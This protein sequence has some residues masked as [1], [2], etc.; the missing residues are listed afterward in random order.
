MIWF[1]RFGIGVELQI[2]SKSTPYQEICIEVMNLLVEKIEEALKGQVS[3]LERRDLTEK[4]AYLEK[5]GGD[6]SSCSNNS[7]G[8]T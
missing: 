1:E 2:G 3:I 5:K 7:D 6:P 8:Y 4:R